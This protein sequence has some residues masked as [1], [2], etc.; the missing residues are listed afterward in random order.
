[1]LIATDTGQGPLHWLLL[2]AGPPAVLALSTPVA[3][4]AR[5]GRRGD[6]GSAWAAGAFALLAAAAACYTVGLFTVLRLESA[7][8]TCTQERFH[9]PDGAGIPRLTDAEDSLLPLGSVCAWEDGTVLD[10]VP[11]FVNP[12]LALLTAAAAVCA[13]LALHRGR[14]ARGAAGG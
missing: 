9:F 7:Y 3:R 4:L 2:L 8:H 10:R 5:R 6:R 14:R 12:A 11:A 1:M 13:A